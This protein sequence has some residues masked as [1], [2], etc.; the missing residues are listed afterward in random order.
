MN[1]L[2]FSIFSSQWLQGGQLSSDIVPPGGDGVV[3]FSDLQFF[4]E[5]WL[6]E[7]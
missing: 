4:V 1:L 6:Q 7:Q 5:Q 2:D 3:N